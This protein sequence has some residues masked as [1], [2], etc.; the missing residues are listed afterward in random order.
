MSNI[1]RKI[2]YD[3]LTGNII[4]HL[5]E[6][7]NVVNVRETT[8]EEDFTTFA[9]LNERAKETVDVLIYEIGQYAQDFAESNGYRVIPE[10]KEIEFSYPDLNEPEVE[11]PFQAPLSAEISTL[12]AS[13]E[14][15]SNYVLEMDMRLVMIEMGI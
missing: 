15:L 2:Y 8:V 3:T 12:K 11:Q 14:D 6:Q 13:N 1:R 5:P 10:T 9:V 7:T 4:L